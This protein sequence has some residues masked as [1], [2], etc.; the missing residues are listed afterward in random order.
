MD[1]DKD[2]E[3]KLLRQ[4]NEEEKARNR[5]RGPNRNSSRSDLVTRR[6]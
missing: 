2:I 1:N 3:S 6:D 5:T 4:T